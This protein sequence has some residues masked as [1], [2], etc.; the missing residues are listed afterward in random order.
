MN[1]T[2]QTPSELEVL[3]VSVTVVVHI[4][5][6]VKNNITFIYFVAT[7]IFVMNERFICVIYII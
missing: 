3:E 1:R 2:H 6:F 4:G 5:I 7:H